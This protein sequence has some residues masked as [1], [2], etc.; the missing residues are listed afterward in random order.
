MGLIILLVT[1]ALLGWLA[2]IALQIEDGREILRNMIAGVL[3]S[4]VVGLATSGGVLLGSIRAS[5]L[6]WSML[7][8]LALI[9]IYSVVRKRALP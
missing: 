8:A 6:L 7:G 4:L 2:T 5:T 1:G 9:A 3:G